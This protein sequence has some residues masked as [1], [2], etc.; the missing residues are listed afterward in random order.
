METRDEG[1]GIRCKD[2]PDAPHDIVLRAE[3]IFSYGMGAEKFAVQL[4]T[5]RTEVAKDECKRIIDVYRKTYA[6]I[7]ELWSAAQNGGEQ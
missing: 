7:P 3:R 5:L 2:H 1:S 6:K 4:K